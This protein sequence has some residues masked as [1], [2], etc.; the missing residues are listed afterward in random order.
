[1]VLLWS[2]RLAPPL[3]SACPA[4][5]VMPWP[6]RSRRKPVAIVGARS[7]TRRTDRTFATAPR[8]AAR[9]IRYRLRS[10]L[11]LRLLRLQ[12][13]SLNR[14]NRPPFPRLRT[15]SFR[16]ESSASAAERARRPGAP[17]AA[18]RE[19]PT[20]APSSVSSAGTRLQIRPRS[21]RRTSG[22]PIPSRERTAPRRLRARPRHR[23][24]RS[25]PRRSRRCARFLH[26]HRQPSKR[27]SRRPRRLRSDRP[28][29]EGRAMGLPLTRA[30]RR[31]SLRFRRGGLRT[32][33]QL[34][35]QRPR[36]SPDRRPARSADAWS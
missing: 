15:P 30:E 23:S 18:A 17:A 28:A 21:R 34:P 26:R 1:M 5:T 13:L 10:R 29:N 36:P 24:L 6:L 9:S 19:P 32:R 11:L 12:H 25:R 8:V 31:R 7:A 2:P 27:S 4:P 35:P 33:L 20:P 16:W 3:P 14:P 22:R